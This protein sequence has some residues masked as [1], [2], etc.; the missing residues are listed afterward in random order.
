LRETIEK[1]EKVG[2]DY[3]AVFKGRQ[4]LIRL[5]QEK[6]TREAHEK[7]IE[8]IN[9]DDYD[10]LEKA[11]QEAEHEKVEDEELIAEAKE[12]LEQ[13]KEY[14]AAK[15]AQRLLTQ[16]EKTRDL[17]TCR[18]AIKMAEVAHLDETQVMSCRAIYMELEF[19][20]VMCEPD[21]I[22][23][24]ATAEKA[25]EFP[26]I[27]AEDKGVPGPRRVWG[28]TQMITKAEDDSVD[29]CDCCAARIRTSIV[30][31]KRVLERLKTEVNRQQAQMKM[32]KAVQGDI[33][34]D[35]HDCIE[36]ALE[37]EVDPEEIM[38]ANDR[39]T[40][41]AERARA[42][43]ELTVAMAGEDLSFLQWAYATA[44]SMSADEQLLAGAKVKITDLEAKVRAVELFK[45]KKAAKLRAAVFSNGRS[46]I[47]SVDAACQ[48]VIEDGFRM[49][50]VQAG[51]VSDDQPGRNLDAKMA[52]RKDLQKALSEGTAKTLETVI[53]AGMRV[54]LPP[55]ELAAPYRKK[56]FAMTDAVHN[57]IAALRNQRAKLDKTMIEAA[58]TS[59]VV[60]VDE[61]QAAPRWEHKPH[62]HSSDVKERKIGNTGLRPDDTI[63]P[64]EM[65]VAPEATQEKGTAS[66]SCSVM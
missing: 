16:A 65:R 64:R 1:A 31:A 21:V 53:Q 15:I 10:E 63:H 61:T 54:G 22:E 51:A 7:L 9:E 2:V 28:I 48:D 30:R 18:E 11:I 23:D 59:P 3:D 35:I 13:L 26:I 34:D 47:E 40:F 56:R 33:I 19:F 4:T 57:D 36:V 44:E 38:K 27:Y 66:R 32:A 24:D 39:V 17:R 5:K 29:W 8:A 41:L 62:V 6:R 45:I 20:E 14:Q 50:V 55:S 25:L 58:S 49:R 37:R 12:V 42:S 60:N 52:V 43:A 46:A